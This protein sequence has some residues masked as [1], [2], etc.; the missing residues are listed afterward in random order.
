MLKLYLR[1]GTGGDAVTA[2][3]Y[4]NKIR[5]RAYGNSYG[6]G[7]VGKLQSTDLNLQ[8]VLDE[9]ARELYWEGHRRTDLDQ[10]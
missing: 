7:N 2:L 1:G 10:V 8:I 4:M 6:P 9:R 3:D 5:F